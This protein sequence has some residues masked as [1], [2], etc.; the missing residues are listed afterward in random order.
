MT[1]KYQVGRKIDPA[2]ANVKF[3]THNPLRMAMLVFDSF[4]AMSDACH[5]PVGE[6]LRREQAAKLANIR[7]Y[8]IDAT[9]Q[10]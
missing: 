9:V 4:E 1:S 10:L 8:W 2:Q 3:L 6:E 5:S 7:V